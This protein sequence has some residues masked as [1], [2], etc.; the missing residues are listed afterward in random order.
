M[1][2]EQPLDIFVESISDFLKALIFQFS[3]HPKKSADENKKL[4]ELA[5][6]VQRI[7]DKQNE[8][9]TMVLD[10]KSA[11][12]RRMVANELCQSYHSNMQ[13]F[14]GRIYNN[15]KRIVDEINHDLFKQLEFSRLFH[16]ADE[17]AHLAIFEHLKTICN[18]ASAH[19]MTSQLPST[20]MGKIS[21]VSKQVAESMQ[22]T[23]K[24]DFELLMRQTQSVVASSD[25]NDLM[26]VSQMLGN[27][28]LGNLDGMMSQFSGAMG[29]VDMRQNMQRAAQ[30]AGSMANGGRAAAAPAA[31]N[32]RALP[33]SDTTQSQF[34]QMQRHY[35]SREQGK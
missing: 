21:A 4:E 9:Q 18:Y 1:D 23:G 11:N 28:S 25:P 32:Q 19:C 8:L 16:A 35:Q 12:L 10:V 17:R 14:Y 33:P 13:H 31:A 15:D 26:Q 30:M 7:R 6:I 34:E 3:P 27:G 20:M 29:N 2:P 22:S 24:M 5:P